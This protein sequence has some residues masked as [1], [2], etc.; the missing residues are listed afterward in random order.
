MYSCKV[1]E[2]EVWITLKTAVWSSHL[3]VVCI[4]IFHW[5]SPFS[6]WDQKK[7]MSFYV[8]Y[9]GKTL[10]SHVTSAVRKCTVLFL[11]HL[12]ENVNFKQFHREKEKSKRMKSTEFLIW[13]MNDSNWNIWKKKKCILFWN[14]LFLKKNYIGFDR[15]IFITTEHPKEWRKKK[16]ERKLDWLAFQRCCVI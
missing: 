9:W 14:R 16:K 4:S 8:F 11:L 2:S 15:V 10:I 1:D 12:N 13:R 6:S 5:I 7:R 3:S